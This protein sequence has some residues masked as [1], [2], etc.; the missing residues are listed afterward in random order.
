MNTEVTFLD[1]SG[2][3]IC[4]SDVIRASGSTIVAADTAVGIDHHNTIFFPLIGSPHWTYSVT[5]RAITMVTQ[6]RK[7]KNRHSRVS[8]FFGTLA[9]RTI[10]R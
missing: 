5:D 4:E 3:G 6:P 8:R 2:N 9:V 1:H 7:E 10:P